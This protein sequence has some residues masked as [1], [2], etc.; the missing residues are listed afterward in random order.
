LYPAM[1]NTKWR[2]LQQ[3]M[4]AL[5]EHSPKW[6]TKC[7]T[8]GYVSNWDGEWFYH[9]SEGGYK[10]IEWVEIQAEN[11]EHRSVIL[12][13]L[14]KVHV[15]GERTAHGFKIYGYVQDGSPVEYL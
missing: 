3:A 4:Y 8:N 5:E 11:E 9:F 1:N 15:P 2:E 12:S 13:E 7:V 6:R 10:D 14:R